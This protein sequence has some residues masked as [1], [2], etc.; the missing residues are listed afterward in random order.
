VA[1]NGTLRVKVCQSVT[2]LCIAVCPRSLPSAVLCPSSVQSWENTW[3]ASGYALA[4]FRRE[5]SARGNPLCKTLRT[6]ALAQQ[7]AAQTERGFIEGFGP[8]TAPARHAFG[9]TLK[10]EGVAQLDVRACRRSAGSDVRYRVELRQWL[11]QQFLWPCDRYVVAAGPAVL[12]AAAR[13]ALYNST[14]WRPGKDFQS[15]SPGGAPCVYVSTSYDRLLRVSSATLTS[16]YCGS[17]RGAE[18][19]SR[20]RLSIR[21]RPGARRVQLSARWSCVVE[22]AARRARLSIDPNGMTRSKKR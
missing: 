7:W 1:H 17:V 9:W 11:A 16:A 22:R 13:R 19:D 6:H 8:A 21:I 20:Q 15:E 12:A 14:S 10:R 5:S 2:P 3:R 4:V 18:A